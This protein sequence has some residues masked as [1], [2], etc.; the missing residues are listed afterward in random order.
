MSQCNKE[1]ADVKT[2]PSPPTFIGLGLDVCIHTI[3]KCRENSKVTMGCPAGAARLLLHLRKSKLFGC[4]TW[5]RPGGVGRAGA[6][7]SCKC[8]C[9]TWGKPCEPRLLAQ[10]EYMFSG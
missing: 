1:H 9:C 8:V 5:I 6:D 2:Y 7:G 10:V 3:Q 4:T